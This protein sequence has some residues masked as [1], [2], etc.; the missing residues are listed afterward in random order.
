M[1]EQF[2]QNQDM[3][4]YTPFGFATIKKEILDNMSNIALRQK[5][6]LEGGGLPGNSTKPYKASTE[7]QTTV[8]NDNDFQT[9][10]GQR[11]ISLF[12]SAPNCTDAACRSHNTAPTAAL[13]A[14]PVVGGKK[15]PRRVRAKSL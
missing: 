3:N 15:K 8:K 6:L 12:G 4:Y 5:K 2:P 7:F 1:V 10:L 14:I 9:R 11:T 13:A